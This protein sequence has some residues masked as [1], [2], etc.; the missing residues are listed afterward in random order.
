[1]TLEQVRKLLR[2]KMKPYRGSHGEGIRPWSKAHGI[3]PAHVSEFL[4]GKRA[5]GADILSALGLEWKIVRKRAA[6]SNGGGS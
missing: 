5:P 6:S 3:H 4:N 1:M 2:R